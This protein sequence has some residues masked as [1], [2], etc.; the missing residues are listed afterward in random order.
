MH[1]AEGAESA[2][3]GLS[4]SHSNY[5]PCVAAKRNTF[6]P[7]RLSFE[8][9]ATIPINQFTFLLFPRGPEPVMVV[10]GGI[11]FQ[12]GPG[13]TVGITMDLG[14]NTGFEVFTLNRIPGG[15]KKFSRFCSRPADGCMRPLK[16]NRITGKSF[17]N[18]RYINNTAAIEPDFHHITVL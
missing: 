8:P 6:K 4:C 1:P 5:L 3:S 13:I 15:I 2:S 10:E 12:R 9:P 14:G 16:Y 17:H 11:S 7:Y 18:I